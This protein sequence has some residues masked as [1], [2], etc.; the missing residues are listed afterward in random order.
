MK[1]FSVERLGPIITPQSDPASGTNI[2]GP[3]LIRVPDWIGQPLGNYYLY[4]AHHKGDRI[5]LAYADTLTGPW[6]VHEPGTV[7]L[8]QTICLEHVA[9]PDVH[10]NPVSREIRMYFHGPVGSLERQFTF[11]ATSNDGIHFAVQNRILGESYFRVFFYGDRYFALARLGR[12]YSAPA[13]NLPFEIA[14]NPFDRLWARSRLR[15]CAVHLRNQT[16]FVFH[17]DIGDC[18]ESIRVS[19][20]D[21]SEPWKQWRASRSQVLLEPEMDYE[22]AGLPRNPSTDGGAWER[23]NQLRD[24]AIFCEN[25]QLYLLYSIAG[26]SGIALAKLHWARQIR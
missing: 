12:L 9:S 24:P 5:K 16:L 6:S 13:P 11:V 19:T 7:Q 1:D 8:S 18:P 22:G 26:E 17:T 3:S 15:H 14:H 4:F 2:N 23:L 20:I 25:G 21:L 10:L